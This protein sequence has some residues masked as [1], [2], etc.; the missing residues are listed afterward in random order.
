MLRD[1]PVAPWDSPSDPFAAV[2]QREMLALPL[3]GMPAKRRD[4]AVFY[5][6]QIDGAREEADLNTDET[7]DE[8]RDKVR[9][10]SLRAIASNYGITQ[11]TANRNLDYAHE[12]G[13][14]VECETAT[15]AGRITPPTVRLRRCFWTEDFW[16]YAA[17]AT[18]AKTDVETDP[19]A[20]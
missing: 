20:A 2:W 19:V 16:N 13:W 1:E 3:K 17:A 15:K 7:S 5:F 18:E 14:I 9:G 11:K 8:N 10:G 6:N 12:R 4:F